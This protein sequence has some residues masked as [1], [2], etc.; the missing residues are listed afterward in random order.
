LTINALTAAHG[1]LIPVQAEYYALAGL[2][3]IQE[4]MQGVIENLNPSLRSIGILLT[5]YD[6]RKSLN[7]DVAKGLKE[8]WGD[9]LFNSVIRDTVALA[10]A[11][12]NGQNIFAYRAKSYGA[13]DYEAFSKEFVQRI[14]K[15]QGVQAR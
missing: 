6:K 5:F 11:P 13:L 3:L 8:R 2:D 12:S 4:S 9:L 10:E 7:R 1:L 15:I 14:K